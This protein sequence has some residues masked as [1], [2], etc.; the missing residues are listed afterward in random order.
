MKFHFQNIFFHIFKTYFHHQLPPQLTP[1]PQKKKDGSTANETRNLKKN[2]FILSPTKRRIA[3][4]SDTVFL[5][6]AIYG[7]FFSIWIKG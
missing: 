2:H 7:E 5:R 1:Y 4:E 6:I 3:R